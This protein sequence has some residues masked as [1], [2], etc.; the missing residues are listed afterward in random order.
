MA[1]GRDTKLPSQSK[2]SVAFALVVGH[3]VASL[4]PH[5]TSLAAVVTR[6]VTRNGS[7]PAASCNTPESIQPVSSATY[8]RIAL[9]SSRFASSTRHD[10]RA[11][12]PA[13]PPPLIEL[14]AADSPAGDGGRSR[15]TVK[16]HE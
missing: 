13:A 16:M 3:T 10:E 12:G 14:V 11:S 15:D 7:S 8:G 1:F 4:S 5:P 6:G 9:T 2:C